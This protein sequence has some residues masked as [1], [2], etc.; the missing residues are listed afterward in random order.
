MWADLKGAS[1]DNVRLV[2]AYLQGA[3]LRETNIKKDQ[4]QFSYTDE[5]TLLPNNILNKKI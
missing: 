2:G 1:F 4:I 3:D 5:D